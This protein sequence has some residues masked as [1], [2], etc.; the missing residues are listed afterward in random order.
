MNDTTSTS[1]STQ[2]SS[3]AVAR[4]DA[5]MDA[6]A[7][8]HG[9]WSDTWRDWAGDRRFRDAIALA[10]DAAV[11]DERERAAKVANRFGP[12]EDIAAAIRTPAPENLNG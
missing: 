3:W 12:H 7:Y 9:P 8:D 6:S 10:L 4:A 5:L 2:P 11:A 1:T